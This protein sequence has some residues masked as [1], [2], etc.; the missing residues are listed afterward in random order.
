[1]VKKV[2]GLEIKIIRI[3][4]GIRQYELAARLGIPANHLSEI[5]SGRRQASDKLL[6]RIIKFLKKK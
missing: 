1:M 4:A 5:E 2:N 3:R 6:T